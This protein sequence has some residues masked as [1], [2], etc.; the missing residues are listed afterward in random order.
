MSTEVWTIAP[1]RGLMEGEGLMPAL[2][3][4]RTPGAEW[5]WL[6]D[7]IEGYEHREGEGATIEVETTP[8]ANPPAGGSSLRHRLVRV[9]S[10]G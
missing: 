10:R 2:R 3:I 4:K 7:E 8:V 6:P 5:E 1:A 9:I